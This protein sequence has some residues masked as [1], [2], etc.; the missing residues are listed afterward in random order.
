MASVFTRRAI[1]YV[2]DFFVVS[3]F[4]WIIAYLLS[5]FINP[6]GTFQIYMYFPY[7]VPV[8]G[9]IYFVVLEKTKGSTVGKALM[10]LRVISRNGYPISWVQAI[11][12]N[13]TKILWFPIIFD[14]AIGKLIRRNDRIF[15]IFTKT[16]VINEVE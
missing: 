3:A 10:Y 5:V 12:R 8:L 6:Y 13:L 7:I 11:V 4:M 15:G 9:L 14:W 2:I 16:M 1:A